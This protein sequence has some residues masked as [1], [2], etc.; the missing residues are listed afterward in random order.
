MY[1]NKKKTLELQKSGPYETLLMFSVLYFR[2]PFHWIRVGVETDGESLLT[3]FLTVCLPY[4][5]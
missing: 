1:Q 4:V 3:F 5:S 2:G